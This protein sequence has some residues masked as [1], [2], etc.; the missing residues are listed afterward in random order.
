M[1]TSVNDAV[2]ASCRNGG[3]VLALMT[4]SS[5]NVSCNTVSDSD[6]CICNDV[7][8][9]FLVEANVNCG[10]IAVMTVTIVT[11]VVNLIRCL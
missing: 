4:P 9:Q 5:V 2:Q 6:N 10:D 11:A 3:D 8:N 1:V 7:C